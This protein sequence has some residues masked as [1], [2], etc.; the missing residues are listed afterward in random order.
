MA[1]GS[2]TIPMGDIDGLRLRD[3][4]VSDRHILAR[5]AAPGCE[6]AAPCDP[7]PWVALG[8]DALPLRAFAPRLRCVC[9]GRLARLELSPG[10]YAPPNRP[11][12]FVFR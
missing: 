3:C 7:A 11:D 10:A 4:L 6:R 1:D 2:Q 9:G 5:C 8:L 12:L